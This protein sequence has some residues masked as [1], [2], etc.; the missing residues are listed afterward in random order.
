MMTEQEAR[1]A[2]EE[3]SR[4][5]ARFWAG[6]AEIARAFF[7]QP[8]SREEHIRWLRLQCFKELYGSGLSASGKGLILELVDETV[9]GYQGLE[10]SVDRH[11][12][13]RTTEILYEEMKHYV[14][15]ADLLEEL[16]GAVPEPEALK[17][18]QLPEDLKLAEVRA[19][20]R[21]EARGLGVLASHFTEGGAAAIFREG[22]NS[23]GDPISDRI[24]YACGQVYED[25]VDHQ[26]SGA[27]GLESAAQS[28][29]DWARVREMVTEICMQRLR[30]RNEQF[31][32]PVTEERL[33]EIAEGKIKVLSAT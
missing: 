19:S 23:K 30:M 11:A 26:D 1:E 12:F 8:R 31:G 14:V 13:L 33:Q 18:H 17:Q 21:G 4:Y 9:D 20:F 15:F 22:M 32:F 16:S 2:L 29:E 28:P 25:E 27:Q 24:A 3:I 10:K 5:A 7:S 6:E